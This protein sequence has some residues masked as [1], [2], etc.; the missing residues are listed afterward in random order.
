MYGI[1]IYRFILLVSYENNLQ[2]FRHNETI[3]IFELLN[4]HNINEQ[5]V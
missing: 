4:S 2:M 3:V 1:K 5:P